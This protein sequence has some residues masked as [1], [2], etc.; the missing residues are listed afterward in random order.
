MLFKGIDINCNIEQFLEQLKEKG[1][2]YTN[3][4]L[5]EGEY[6]I[7]GK[8]GGYKCYGKVL[9]TWKTHKVYDVRVVLYERTFDN[10]YSAKV[11]SNTFAM[12]YGKPDFEI[13][14][15]DE[16]IGF[17]AYSC[18]FKTGDG[19]IRVNCKDDEEKDHPSIEYIYYPNEE[20]AEDEKEEFFY[21]D[22]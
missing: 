6:N 13:N 22:L 15:N 7:K 17:W 11:F 20:F 14:I 10:Y 5:Q 4:D 8:F 3:K 18:T 1:F 9:F 19:C 16:K 2:E 12:K 21:D